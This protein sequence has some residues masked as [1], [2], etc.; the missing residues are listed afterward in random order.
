MGEPPRTGDPDH[1]ADATLIVRRVLDGG[2][3]AADELRLPVCDLG[4]DGAL[5]QPARAPWREPR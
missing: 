2:E 5:D 3:T 1:G 4:L